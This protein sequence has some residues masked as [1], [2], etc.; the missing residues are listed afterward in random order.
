MSTLLIVLLVLLLIGALPNWGYHN[1][2]YWP[3]LILVV[4]IVLLLLGKI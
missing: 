2:G 4:I 1:F 3:G